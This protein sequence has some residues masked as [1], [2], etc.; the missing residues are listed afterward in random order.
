MLKNLKF[1]MFNV[2]LIKILL[3]FFGIINLI[4]SE[5]KFI[6]NSKSVNIYY[7][8]SNS[9]ISEIRIYPTE[10]LLHD[11]N[12]NVSYSKSAGNKVS[13]NRVKTQ[14][15]NSVLQ[16]E[17]SYLIFKNSKPHFRKIS[18]ADLQYLKFL[19]ITKMLC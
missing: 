12:L 10:N 19:N 7:E 14:S 17:N 11:K 3:S 4:N 6:S 8:K 1:K 16:K 2:C 15:V 5:S 9:K 18:Y 13:F